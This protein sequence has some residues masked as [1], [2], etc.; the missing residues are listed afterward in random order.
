MA[1]TLTT[2]DN[3]HKAVPTKGAIVNEKFGQYCSECIAQTS[4]Q[5]LGSS[6]QWHRDRD[7]EE[8]RRDLIQAHD[9]HGKPNPEFIRNYPEEAAGIFTKEEIEKHGR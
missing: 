1:E 2:C 9:K 6:A 4:R 8:N 7:H 5:A 3:C